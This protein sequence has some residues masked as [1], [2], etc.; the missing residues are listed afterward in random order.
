MKTAFPL[1]EDSKKRTNSVNYGAEILTELC[2]R[3]NRIAHQTDRDPDNAIQMP[4]SSDYVRHAIS[5]VE[6]LVQALHRA[7][8]KLDNT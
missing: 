8:E 4:I 5:H 7:A 2:I 1:P 6:R 3:R